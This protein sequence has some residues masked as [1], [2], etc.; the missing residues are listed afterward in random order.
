MKSLDGNGTSACLKEHQ[1]GPKNNSVI[2]RKKILL[3]SKKLVS[4]SS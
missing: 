1:N 4:S 2:A 3:Q